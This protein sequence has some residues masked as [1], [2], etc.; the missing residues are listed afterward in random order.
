MLLVSGFHHFGSFFL[1]ELEC[2]CHKLIMVRAI[3]DSCFK[4][5]ACLISP[6]S[7]C[8]PGHSSAEEWLR[9]WSICDYGKFGYMN[10][11]C[12]SGMAITQS[13]SATFI[14]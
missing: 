1:K 5:D 8:V 2:C 10:A 12:A 7:L 13:E 11:S 14:S 6:L 9:L 4:L 3:T